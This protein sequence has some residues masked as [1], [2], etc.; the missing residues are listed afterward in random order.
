[1]VHHAIRNCVWDDLK[2]VIAGGVIGIP[3]GVSLLMTTDPTLIRW[4]VS[5]FILFSLGLLASGWRYT[6]TPRPVLTFGVG[7]VSGTLSGLATIGGPPVIVYMLG[8]TRPVEIIRSNI[9]TYFA[10]MTVVGIAMFLYRGLFTA[11]VLGLY[12]IIAPSYGLGLFLGGRMFSLA[13]PFIFRLIAYVLIAL[14]ALTSMPA[15]DPLLRNTG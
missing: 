11:Q 12:F 10:A 13:S 1:M 2:Y 4:V 5:I 6:G 14:S 3:F 15:L 7:T 9:F 8:G